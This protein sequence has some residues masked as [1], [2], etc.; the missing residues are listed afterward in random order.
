M[1]IKDI[2]KIF[3]HL[4]F[5]FNAPVSKTLVVFGVLSMLVSFIDL[6]GLENITLTLWPK[7]G[8]LIISFILTGAGIVV[9]LLAPEEK[10]INKKVNI[11]KG[12]VLNLEQTVV[13]LKVGK[14]Q[15]VSN[16]DKTS[17]VVLPANTSFVDDCITDENSALGA[18]FKKYHTNKI[19]KVPKD[20]EERLQRLGYQRSENGTYPL[21]TTIILPDEYDTPAKTIITASTVRGNTG[22]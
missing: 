3:E 15:D 2:E 17:A 14:I 1:N 13:N 11:K 12:L 21:G 19:S 16:G 22:H 10:R 6:D 9:F 18:F 4:K 8:I 20:I 7:W 5:I